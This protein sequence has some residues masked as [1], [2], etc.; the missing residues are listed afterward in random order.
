MLL[1]RLAIPLAIG[2]AIVAIVVVVILAGTKNSHLQLE[3][4]VIKARTGALDDNSSAAVMDFRIND[5][6]DVPF[7]VGQVQVKTIRPDGSELDGQVISRADINL[8]LQYNRFLGNQYNPVLVIRDRVKPHEMFDRMVAARFDLS[9]KDLDAS[10]ALR[11]RVQDVDG[12][13]FETDYKLR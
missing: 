10:R 12:A 6:S 1:K 8:L 11:L 9:Q 5:P 3:M 7:V 4:R 13:W 2:L